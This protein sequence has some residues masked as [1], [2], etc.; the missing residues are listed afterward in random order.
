MYFGCHDGV[1]CT[2]DELVIERNY[3]HGVTVG[4]LEQ[5][6]GAVALGIKR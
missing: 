4:T 2:L 1:M 3:I 5:S 6:P